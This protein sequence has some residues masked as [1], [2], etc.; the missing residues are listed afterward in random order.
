AKLQ[1]A[2]RAADLAWSGEPV[3]SRYNPP[4]T[5][6]FMRRNEILG[7]RNPTVTERRTR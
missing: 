7:P 1:A 4:F 2:L 6:W 3:Y 5:P